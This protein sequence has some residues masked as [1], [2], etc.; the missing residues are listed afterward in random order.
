MITLEH[1]GV[2][3]SF[4]NPNFGDTQDYAFSDLLAQNR[5]GESVRVGVTRQKFDSYTW[6]FSMLTVAK[7]IEIITFLRNTQGQIIEITDYAGDIHQAIITIDPLPTEAL[8]DRCRS[9]FALEF[10]SLSKVTPAPSV[11]YSLLFEDASDSL[12]LEDGF[13]LL[14]EDAP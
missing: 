2:S 7:L 6:P 4:R 10:L 11:D 12:G 1:G 5:Y 13:Y 9:N 14:T 8:A 3:V